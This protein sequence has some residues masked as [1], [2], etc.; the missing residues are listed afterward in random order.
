M[1]DYRWKS[2]GRY[3]VGIGEVDIGKNSCTVSVWP[4][5]IKEEEE[6]GKEKMMK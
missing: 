2:P 4:F 3:A 5:I 1:V 6:G